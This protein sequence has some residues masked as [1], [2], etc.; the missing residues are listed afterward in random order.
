MPF[1]LRNAPPVLIAMMNY[2]KA[3]CEAL[4][5]VQKFP[6]NLDNGSKIIA[7][8]V[9]SFAQSIDIVFAILCNKCLITRKYNLTWKFKKC[10]FFPT[11]VEFV[12]FRVTRTGNAPSKPKIERLL[13]WPRMLTPRNIMQ[14]LSF[15]NFYLK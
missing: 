8:N 3:E 12:G 1:Y 15:A 11:E 4:T 13:K 9:F 6:I 10:H 14:F 2:L 5:V 7:D